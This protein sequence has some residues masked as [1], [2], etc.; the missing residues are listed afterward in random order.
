MGVAWRDYREISGSLCEGRGLAQASLAEFEPS[1]PHLSRFS[2]CGRVELDLRI[3]RMFGPDARLTP[4][5][6]P[7]HWPAHSGSTPS[8]ENRE[9]W[10]N[11][12]ISLAKKLRTGPIY[13]QF[14][15][16]LAI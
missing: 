9:G 8:F 16:H 12:G 15:Q 2:K 10:G 14:G 5:I 11:H 7:K 13:R 6:Q 3:F 1:L 4:T